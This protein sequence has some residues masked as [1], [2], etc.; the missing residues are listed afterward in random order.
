MANLSPVEC[1]LENSRVHELI[2]QQSEKDRHWIINAT[3][4]IAKFLKTGF[5]FMMLIGHPIGGFVADLLMCLKR[6]FCFGT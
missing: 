4:V 6:L 1:F 2:K 5:T 3:N